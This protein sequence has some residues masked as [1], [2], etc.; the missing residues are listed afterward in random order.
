FHGHSIILS[1]SGLDFPLSFQKNFEPAPL[2]EKILSPNPPVFSTSESVVAIMLPPSRWFVK[3]RG[4]IKR[5]MGNL[6]QDRYSKYYLEWR[7]NSTN[8][9]VW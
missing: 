7:E 4:A 8:L 2:R 1:V 3:L 6:S 9:K 5:L